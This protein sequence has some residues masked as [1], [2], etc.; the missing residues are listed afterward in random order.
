MDMNGNIKKIISVTLAI[1]V[2]SAAPA[3][4][5]NLLTTKAYATSTNNHNYLDSLKLLDKNDDNIKLYEDKNY[6]DKLNDDDVEAGNTYYAKTSSHTVSI[7]INGPNK[8]YVKVFKEP[9]DSTKS[10]NI[11]DNITL[12]ENSTY[13]TIVINVYGVA[14]S[15]DISYID[16]ANY[17][18]LSTYKIKVKYTG[19]DSINSDSSS[20][21]NSSGDL[22]ATDYGDIYLERLSVNGSMIELLDSKIE[23]TCDVDSDV[24]EATIRATPEEDDY[25]VTIDDKDVDKNDNYKATVNLDKGENKFKVEIEHKSKDRVYTLVINRGKTSST[26]TSTTAN[27]TTSTENTEATIKA[28]QWVLI[29]GKWQYNDATGKL[30]RNSWVQNYY[31][32]DDGNMA[33]GWLNY[34]GIWYY[35]GKYGAMKTE[36]QLIDGNWY[37]FD[38]EGKMKTGWFKDINGKYYYLTPFGA[39]AYNTTING[40]KL[41]ADG[42]WIR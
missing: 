28:N 25:Y 23:Y 11:G 37:Y 12:S 14:P 1:G 34:S 20:N 13:T 31:L 36:W 42:A 17:Q 38:S 40:Y 3:T 22:T 7:D 6:N 10:K 15:G 35:L 2:I 19:S 24:D 41:G 16:S 18:I 39:M 8:D 32:Q 26:T 9:S 21:N 4:N 27:T 30:V 29:N 33:T 5:I